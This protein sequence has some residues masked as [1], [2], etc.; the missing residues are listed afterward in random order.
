M[1][2]NLND[3]YSGGELRFTEFGDDRYRPAAGD[4]VIFSCA[5]LHEVIPVTRGKRFALLTFLYDE[6]ARRRDEI[7]PFDV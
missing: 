4:A 6:T 7:N 3:D 2:L 5:H 1:S